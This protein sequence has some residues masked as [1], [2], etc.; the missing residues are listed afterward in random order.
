MHDTQ[1]HTLAHDIWRHRRRPLQA[2]FSPRTVAVIGAT[3]TPG[4][5]GRTIFWNL[6]STPFGGTVFPVNPK[7]PS[8]MGVKAYPTVAEVPAEIDLAV[9]VTPASTVPGVIRQCVDAGIGAAIIISAGFK[10]LGPPGAA[11]EAE[12]LAE[13]RRGSMRIIGPNCLGVM[14]PLGGLNATFARGMA[15]PGNI[16][17]ISQSGALLTAILDW[18]ESEQVG[19]SGIVSTG[20][21]LDVG[22]G[23]LIEHFGD[24]PRTQA[25]MLYMESIGDARSFVSA[26][27]EVALNKPII[28]IKAGRSEEAARAA[29]SHTGSL[30]GSDE[31]LDAACWRSGVLRV[32]T[33][34]ELFDMAEILSKQPR[35][36]GPK[37]TI[38]TNAGGP[39]VLATDALV[40]AGGQLAELGEETLAA[41]DEV[42]PAAWSHANPIDILGDA[43]PAR[44]AA[45]LEI[46][47]KDPN[48][49][50]LLV[51]LTPQDMTD[52]TL[53]A[54]ALQ[55]YARSPSKP[56]LASFMG[57]PGIEAANRILNRAGIP[58]FHYPD[59]VATAFCY[60]WRYA[61]NLE[62]LY[63]TPA[64]TDVEIV[65]AERGRA[66]VERVR[67]EGRQL[68]DEHDSKQ[69]LASY[70]IPVVETVI[71]VTPEEAVRAAR[72]IGYPV[73]VKLHSRT[74]THK[75]D[76]GGVKLDLRSDEA[77][78]AAFEAIREGAERAGGAHHFQGV[79]V[80]RMVELASSYE[81]IVG[82]SVDPQFGPVL[83]FGAGGQLV[84]VFRDRALAL[85][86]LDG[87]LA[88]R[89]M[90]RTRIFRALEGVRGRPPVALDALE[91]V[92]VRFSQL[93][94]EQRWIREIEI[95][96]LL[97]SPSGV[98][99]LDARVV[100]HDPDTAEEDLP[101]SAIRPYPS[102]YV[103]PWVLKDGTQ[104]L[105][106]PIRPEDEPLMVDFHHRLSER[107]VRQRYFQVLQLDQRTAHERLIRVCFTDYDRDLVL[108]T[109]RRDASGRREILAV[110]RL[111]KTLDRRA[112]EFAIVIADD[113]QHLGIGTELLRRL[114]DIGR[115][116]NLSAIFA[117]ILPDNR[118]MQHVCR[119]VGFQLEFGDSVV[120]ARYQL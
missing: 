94:L 11:L 20:S 45:A 106:R 29:A 21:M 95:N 83:L 34:S 42:L 54:E 22:W 40:S 38:V 5:V 4:A 75:T 118:E 74:L 73:A 90:A 115:Q 70:G 16:A 18:S 23:D 15:R 47:A 7:R 114:V 104:V 88:R 57:G 37:L 76:V 12:V 28:V 50:G 109:E 120:S 84:E 99:A 110:G 58:T 31:V 63:R 98:V 85:P 56:V 91:Q 72:D 62:G 30:T 25:I 61:Y 116:E 105:M 81:L 60:M 87:P 65:D 82:S 68:L 92:L 48:S 86:P 78:T 17:F 97:A 100:L 102:Q 43:D 52:P 69:L 10:E 35:P 32:D 1:A 112:A 67:A 36:A 55:R 96:P 39:A 41:L 44:Y 59:A 107:S 9:V 111:S 77:V 46:A 71:A 108:V 49:D 66:I 13:A 14:N 26:A 6:L 8:V 79:T 113:W 101:R 80:Q 119:K 117:D 33:I 103:A 24:D 3:E 53:T 2:F 27:R 51:I 89:T 64:L 19:F 93:V